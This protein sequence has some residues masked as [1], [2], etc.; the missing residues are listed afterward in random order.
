MHFPNSGF[1]YVSSVSDDLDT[2]VSVL[3]TVDQRA[4]DLDLSF[5]Q[6][7]V[8]PTYL[9]VSS[10]YGKVYLYPGVPLDQLQKAIQSF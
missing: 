6:Q 5:N 4:D 10:I 8:F 3:Q 2:H 1:I 7:S 9:M